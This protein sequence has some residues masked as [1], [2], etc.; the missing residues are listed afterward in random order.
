MAKGVLTM[1]VEKK[2]AIKKRLNI[3]TACQ[4]IV[5]LQEQDFCDFFV[6][7]NNRFVTADFKNA[8]PFPCLLCVSI[9]IET[10]F[11]YCQ[12]SP[13]MKGKLCKSLVSPLNP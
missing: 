11:F 2:N 13:E 5:S 6:V 4:T 7:G 3:C 8:E 10:L 1:L 9:V 12:W